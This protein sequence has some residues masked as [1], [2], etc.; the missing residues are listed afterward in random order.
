MAPAE[1]PGPRRPARL[2]QIDAQRCTGCGWCIAACEPHVLSLEVV[3]WK[4]VSVLH[5]PSA[6]TGCSLCALKC[7]FN[8]I[9][10]QKVPAVTL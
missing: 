8:A 1:A 6:C 3:H 4:K 9:T 10:M 5:T 2:P 7:P